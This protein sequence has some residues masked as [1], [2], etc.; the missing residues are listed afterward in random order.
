M[1]ADFIDYRWA[2]PG[3]LE[4]I[5][6]KADVILCSEDSST[7]ISEAVWSRLPVVGFSP[8]LHD[9]KP[10]EGEYRDFLVRNNWCRFLPMAR[11]SVDRFGSALSEISPLRVNPL[12]QLANELRKRL[13]ELLG[14]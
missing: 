7:M 4:R 10:E 8:K 12:D 9:F 2:G 13:P 5:F 3:T 1:V 11:L 6:S 14:G